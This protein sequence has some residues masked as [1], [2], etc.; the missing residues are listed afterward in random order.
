[1]PGRRCPNISPSDQNPLWETLIHSVWRR[2]FTFFETVEDGRAHSCFKGYALQYGKS[3]RGRGRGGGDPFLEHV[4]FE[5]RYSGLKRVPPPQSISPR[6]SQRV[7]GSPR[8]RAYLASSTQ[9]G[10]LASRWLA[11]KLP[12]SSPPQNTSIRFFLMAP[13]TSWAKPMPRR[14]NLPRFWSGMFTP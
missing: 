4:P 12:R 1:M 2:C 10:P 14:G 11:T 8:R 3:F 7:S 6:H 13:P 5:Q 9:A